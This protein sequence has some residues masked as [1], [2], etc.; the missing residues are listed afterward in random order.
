L[1]DKGSGRTF[2]K[3]VDAK[4]LHYYFY[5]ID[6]ELGL[7]YL[8]VPTWAPF[9][10]QFYFN[11][12]N[13]LAA[14]LRK[15]GIEHRLVDDVFTE[16]NDYARAQTLVDDL[17]IK[18]LHRTLDRMARQC[19]RVVRHFPMGIHW[20]LMQIEYATDIVFKSREVLAPLYDQCVRTAIHALKADDIATFLGRKLDPRY[21]GEVGND[22]HLRVEGTRIKHHMG[23]VS[24]KMYDKLGPG[25]PHRDHSQRRYLLQAPPEG[26]TP[27]R[28]EREK[29]RPGQ[30][31]D[32]QSARF[33][34]AHGIREPPL[35]GLSRNDR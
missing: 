35:P 2:L 15:K 21:E 4:C 6:E 24:I 32:L 19:C 29:S 27:R 20:S 8:R 7:C 34:R 12:H 30:E 3:Y 5:F 26:G 17:S 16:I 9:R 10:L 14:K 33:E 28:D 13:Q 25:A 18:S 22:F 11:G 1:H 31:D 23:R